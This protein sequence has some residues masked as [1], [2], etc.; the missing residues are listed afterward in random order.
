MRVAQQRF[1][2]IA[3]W[4]AAIAAGFVLWG[5]ESGEQALPTLD[6]EDR[7][8]RTAA[9]R[10]EQ[11]S[12]LGLVAELEEVGVP[13]GFRGGQRHEGAHLAPHEGDPIHGPAHQAAGGGR[14]RG[15]RGSVR[16]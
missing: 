8:V 13:R 3:M 11:T 12:R 5:G 1:W 7:P 4:S 14:G 9:D 10:A 15:R 16:W 2:L 6:A